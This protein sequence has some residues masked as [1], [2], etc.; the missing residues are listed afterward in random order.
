MT[1]LWRT[2]RPFCLT[3]LG[4]LCIASLSQPT[5]AADKKA[6]TPKKIAKV[7]PLK[8]LPS[9]HPKAEPKLTFAQF[10]HE[11]CSD[12]AA[13]SL[14]TLPL[15]YKKAMLATP[16]KEYSG[17]DTIKLPE[18][19]KTCTTDVRDAYQLWASGQ[20]KAGA[21][22]TFKD[23]STLLFHTLGISQTIKKP[24]GEFDL[25][26]AASAGARY[27]F[28]AYVTVNKVEGLKSGLY[29]YNPKA[30]SLVLLK[31]GEFSQEL[32]SLC[33]CPDQ[34][35]SAPATL[36]FT[37]SIVRTASRYAQRSYRY[38]NMDTGHAAYNLALCAATLGLRAPMIVR[39][40][41]EK[42]NAFL[43][44][45][46]MESALLVQPLGAE[47]EKEGR[48]PAF[49]LGDLTKAKEGKGSFLD[50][51][52]GG[53]ELKIAKGLGA[54]PTLKG[55]DEGGQKQGMERIKLPAPCVG[56]A[57]FQSIQKRRSV[58]EY[59]QESM[60]L[61]DFSALCES[62]VGQPKG[63]PSQDPLLSG[64]APINIYVMVRDVKDL[65]PGIYR[66]HPKGHEVELVKAGDFA[67]AATEA[68]YGQDFAGTAQATFF[69]TIKWTELAQPDGDRGYRYA[70][71]RAGFI[72]EGLYVQG[73]ALN[74]GAC[75]IGAFEDGATN[76]LL[77]L[78]TNQE[79][80]LYATSTGKNLPPKA[81]GAK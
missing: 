49:A 5:F 2:H 26:M 30:E 50:F 75:G 46:E 20:A 47:A 77:D 68:C 44:V 15:G 19:T 39:F 52:H 6:S 14:G 63:Q 79:V 35:R 64:S 71:L 67:N 62:S 33:G 70:C 21:N 29:Y 42:L 53:T 61:G 80:C 51:I 45:D 81:E 56:S 13:V 32:A 7:N 40:E 37:S 22:L 18:P 58:R 76:K 59:A 28:N 9:R 3:A 12:P 31:A 60:S 65:K 43:G 41:D 25:R 54:R 73:A 55:S 1:S 24:R 10:Y 27:P 23:L 78:D 16:I 36:V 72:S 4:F 48:E 57:L 8:A 38:V 66:Y 74:I 34:I 11:G 69:K 17:K